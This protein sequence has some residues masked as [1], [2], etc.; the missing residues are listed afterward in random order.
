MDNE[1][2]VGGY[3]LMCHARRIVSDT[4]WERLYSIPAGKAS[5]RQGRLAYQTP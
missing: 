2:H 4:V 1:S 5:R 3:T